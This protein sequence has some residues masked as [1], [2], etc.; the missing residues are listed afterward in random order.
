MA[1]QPWLGILSWWR[2]FHHFINSFNIIFVW[3][4]IQKNLRRFIMNKDIFAGNW[5]QLSGKIK[6]QWGELTDDEIAK[7]N[8]KQEELLGRLQERYGYNKQQ[9]EEA[10]NDFIKRYDEL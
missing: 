2:G 8:G 9:A 4:I 10:V 3:K 1:L 6:Q 5:K 7:I